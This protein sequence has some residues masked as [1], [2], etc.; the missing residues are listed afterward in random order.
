MLAATSSLRRAVPGGATFAEL[1]ATAGLLVAL[2]VVSR[3]VYRLVQ[4]DEAAYRS[5]SITLAALATPKLVVLVLAP[6]V[7]VVWLRRRLRWC[8]VTEGGL[9]RVLLLAA[10]GSLLVSMAFYEGNWFLGQY[11]L[12]DRALLVG[13]CLLGAWRPIAL[14]PFTILAAITASQFAIPLGRYTWNDKRLVFDVLILFCL[15]AGAGILRKKEG[16]RAFLGAVGVLLVSWYLIAAAG[17]VALLWPS[18]EELANMTRSAHLAG[19]LPGDKAGRL[20]ELVTGANDLMIFAAIAV[21]VAT[22]LL[23]LGRRPALVALLALPGL[24]LAVFLLSGIFFWKWMVLEAALAFFVVRSRRETFSFRPALILL[25]LPVAFFSPRLFGVA[26]LAWYDTP[27]TVNLELEAVGLSGTAY[28]I[29]RNDMAPY[30][31][32]LAQ[33][34]LG[35]V[36]K[37]GMLVGSLGTALDWEVASR[38]ERARTP[39]DLAEAE[40]QLAVSQYKEADALVFDRFV[41]ARFGDWVDQPPLRPPHHIWTG[42][43]P[44]FLNVPP[45]AF[46]G[47]E[48]VMEVR[49]RMHKVWW[50]GQ[51]YRPLADC[52][53]RVVAIAEP[54]RPS[55]VAPDTACPV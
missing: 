50:D 23:L 13:L 37:P 31:V 5:S 10:A 6:A 11:H 19:W 28:R 1:G 9:V 54:L 46:S 18:R 39:S 49:V 35:F 15:A 7:V 47:Q 43:A 3:V 14:V 22:V 36:A 41:R 2:A 38:I 4:L 30:E 29:D 51:R 48:E 20:A 24:H 53:V 40:E 44:A 17:K 33:G 12:T 32:L 42:R 16:L 45:V 34:R 21:E 27:Y 8:D 25:A 26:T 55:Y 52:I